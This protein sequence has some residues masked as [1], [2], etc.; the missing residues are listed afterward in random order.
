MRTFKGLW[1]SPYPGF[2]YLSTRITR[3]P[4]YEL[5]EDIYKDKNGV[6]YAYQRNLVVLKQ[7]V[8]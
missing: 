3:Y 7:P 4:N 8:H 6:L 5:T 1:G 2:R